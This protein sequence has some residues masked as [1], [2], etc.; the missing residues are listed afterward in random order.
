MCPVP[1]TKPVRERYASS[2]ATTLRSHEEGHAD[3]YTSDV[4]LMTAEP[5]RMFRDN[6]FSLVHRDLGERPSDD[7]SIFSAERM[8]TNS[9]ATRTPDSS[10]TRKPPM[11]ISCR[12][13]AAARIRRR[14]RDDQCQ[15][16]DREQRV[17]IAEE[18]VAVSHQ[19][20][21]VSGRSTI[22]HLTA[23][24]PQKLYH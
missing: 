23:I 24:I 21:H 3:Q 7:L 17:A 12:G 1:G 2:A 14:K 13:L 8:Y 18:K 10:A 9:D 22:G 4:G 16:D 19:E 6:V 11:S 15:Q 5:T 20:R